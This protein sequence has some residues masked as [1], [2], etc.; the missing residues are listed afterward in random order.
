MKRWWFAI[1]GAVIT[2]GAIT[3]ILSQSELGGRSPNR[4]R[5]SIEPVE[6]DG[7]PNANESPSL[8]VSVPGSAKGRVPVAVVDLKRIRTVKN[9]PVNERASLAEIVDA[10]QPVLLAVIDDLSGSPF[11]KELQSRYVWPAPVLVN[12]EDLQSVEFRFDDSVFERRIVIDARTTAGRPV[13]GAVFEL[14]VVHSATVATLPVAFV[15]SDDQGLAKSPWLPRGQYRVRLNRAPD[16]LRPV[17][18]EV[19]QI[20]LEE[21]REA[22]VTFRFHSNGRITGVVRGEPNRKFGVAV[23]GRTDSGL[24]FVRARHTETDGTFEV[25][26]L[27]PGDYVAVSWPR[28]Y[29]EAS[30]EFSVSPGETTDVVLVPTKGGTAVVAR[31]LDWEGKPLARA[32]VN[33]NAPLR[34][35][36]RPSG[37]PFGTDSEGRLRAVGVASGQRIVILWDYGYLRPFSV[38]A[39]TTEVDLG[40]FRLPDLKGGV[41]VQGD[42]LDDKGTALRGTLICLRRAG[43]LSEWVRFATTDGGGRYRFERVI[44]GRYLVWHEPLSY[45]NFV[46]RERPFEVVVADG[47]EARVDLR[48]RRP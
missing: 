26:S 3:L 6:P 14:S 48:L 35:G 36:L 30:V 43:S 13:A 5:T 31:L 7:S 29:M 47:A 34:P 27:P 1:I 42:V 10:G 18:E 17:D 40:T 12:P 2:V 46:A 4:D 25:E 44:P 41:T 11:L 15:R 38:E 16:A 24:P 8:R 28:G 19:V 39:G 9:V 32:R 45:T 23:F 20:D 22:S 21:R 33:I 37:R